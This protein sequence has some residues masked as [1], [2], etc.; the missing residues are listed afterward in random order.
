MAN[1]FRVEMLRAGKLRK[2]SQTALITFLATDTQ[3]GFTL[4]ASAKLSSDLARQRALVDR[5]RAVIQCVRRLV[6]HIEDATQS[7]AIHNGVNDLE[8]ALNAHLKPTASR[9][10]AVH[11]ASA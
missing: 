2:Q 8:E 6:G 7:K 9:V 5:T 11:S 10:P 4:L 3:V 1:E